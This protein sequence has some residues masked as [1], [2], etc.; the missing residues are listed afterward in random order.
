MT[1]PN[2]RRTYFIDKRMQGIWA[3]IN[4]TIAL[5]V[6]LFIG[7]ELIRSFH[8][9]FGWPLAGR[10]FSLPDLMFIIKL[11]I[12]ALIGSAFFW[13]LSA[14]EGRRIA[15]PIYRLDVSL[16]DVTKGNYSLR[17]Q[18]RKKDFF[19]HI[20]E[21][22]NE[23][24]GSLENKFREKDELIEKIKEKVNS[25]PQENAQVQELKKILGVE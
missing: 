5:I 21:T 1:L 14:Y 10:P 8:T 17:I 6:A 24:N 4:L 9:E 20:A 11:I 13:L 16:K 23:M 12:L 25:L 2:R 19:Q 7:G 3:L 15:G 18:F 22:F